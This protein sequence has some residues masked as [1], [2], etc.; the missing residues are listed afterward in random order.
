MFVKNDIG[1]WPISQMLLH[2]VRFR[3]EG[4]PLYSSLI[5]RRGFSP[6]YLLRFGAPILVFMLVFAGG[7]VLGIKN[8]IPAASKLLAGSGEIPGDAPEWAPFWKAWSALNSKFVGSSTPSGE[9][10][11][12][13][14]IQG[15]TSS[16]GDPFTVF[17]PPVE[18]KNFTD[19]ISGSFEGVGMEI[20]TKDGALSVISPLK[21]SP[22]ERAGILPADKIIK[23]DGE[24]SVKMPVEAAVKR[25]RGK[26]GTTIVLTIIHPDSAKP[27]E[28][29]IVREA[30]VVPSTKTELRGDGVFVISLYSF[31]APS[32]GEF[33]SALRQFAESGA[34]TLLIDLRNNPGG[35]LEAAVD[36]GSWF[37]PVGKPIV[38]EDFGAKREPEIYRSKG[39]DVFTEQLT[40][41]ILMNGGS[42]SASE[43]LAGALRDHGKAVLLGEKSFG[44][45]SVQELVPITD[46]TNLKVTIARWLTPSGT[47]ISISGLKPDV[48]IKLTEENIK[49]IRSGGKDAQLE[50][51]V[52]YLLQKSKEK[53]PVVSCVVEGGTLVCP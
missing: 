40:L 34:N 37:L 38:R 31:S 36:M 5:M 6:Y 23:I 14:S 11:L 33:R 22:A 12:W 4:F 42:A 53:N 15:L 8:S 46:N 1:M 18:S 16:Y 10:K 28:V 49:T 25:I 50:S 47:S 9:E 7:Y 52:K 3:L 41:G 29:S 20:G 48:E 19:E 26:A 39:Y 43:I 45:G 51:A 21:G 27:I 24:D 30:I 35:Y 32:P 2:C 17:F 13:G 44:K